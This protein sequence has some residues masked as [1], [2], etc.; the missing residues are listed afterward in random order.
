MKSL[1]LIC[2]IALGLNAKIID[3]GEFI[4]DYSYKFKGPSNV[5]YVLDERS[6]EINIK[7]RNSFYKDEELSPLT[8]L[9]PDDVTNTG[10]DRGHMAS[11]AS[12]D[13]DKD[14]LNK[15]YS[16]ANI[17]LQYPNV[18]R[19]VWASLE[20]YER[21]NISQ[22]GKVYVRNIIVYGEEILK[23]RPLEEILLKRTFK[24]EKDKNDYIKRYEREAKNLEAKKIHIPTFFIK[25]IFNKKYDFEECY[26]V[27]N[28]ENLENNINLYQIDCKAL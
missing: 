13:Y 12:F 10:F 20:E 26:K 18:N 22:L 14:V 2:L 8:S 19:N 27:P 11:D 25:K 5:S 16:M 28:I 1:F 21:Y 17:A 23:K 24:T 6:N 4:I 15:T 9:L 7:E 3:K